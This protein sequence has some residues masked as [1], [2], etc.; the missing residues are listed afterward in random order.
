MKAVLLTAY[1]SP[2][3]I[4]DVE[5]YYTKILGGRK[6]PA[7]LLDELRSR[8]AAIGGISPLTEITSRQACSLQAMLASLGSNIAV[9]LGMKYTSPFI[10]EVVSRMNEEGVKSMLLLPLTPFNSSVSAE[11]YLKIAFEAASTAGHSVTIS[12]PGP[13]H[14]NDHFVE[15]W[16]KLINAELRGKEH[17]IFTAHSIPKKYIDAG[18][19]YREQ[20]EELASLLGR[21]LGIADSELAFQSAGRTSEEW[22][23]PSLTGRIAAL[24]R[25]GHSEALIVPIGFVSEHLEVLYDIDIEAKEAA[26]RAGMSVRRTALPDDHPLFIR[27]LADVCLTSR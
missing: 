3:G 26:A 4:D 8:Y 11:S 6:P 14:L 20:L 22:I 1:G 21:K 23:G 10:G 24:G 12:S 15:C 5:R 2:S 7:A 19:P 18:E 13:W 25:D 17:V 27:A 16:E 9:R